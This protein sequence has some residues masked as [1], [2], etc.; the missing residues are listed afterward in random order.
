M[1][2]EKGITLIALIITI[3]VMLILVAVTIN[4]ALNGGLFEKAKT[5]SDGTQKEAD[6]EALISA[7][8]GTLNDDGTVNLINLQSHLP[9]GF[10][11]SNGIYTSRDSGKQYTVDLDTGRVQ[12][13]TE[14]DET[15]AW[16]NLGLT[17]PNVQYGVT[18]TRTTGNDGASSIIFYANG[19]LAFE[20]GNEMTVSE[21]EN[22]Y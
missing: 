18:Y 3:I 9:E 7:V 4:V 16:Y 6:R 13:Y 8:I 17:S 21:L 5:A 19:T 22:T 1:K 11:Y 20:G 10:V 14:T 15:N 2:K 12:E